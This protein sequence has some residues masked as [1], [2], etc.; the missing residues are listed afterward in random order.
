MKCNS[1]IL[2]PN[3]TFHLANTIQVLHKNP[4]TNVACTQTQVLHKNP[5]T[6]VACTQTQVLHKTPHT[7]VACTQTNVV[8]FLS[9]NGQWFLVYFGGQDLLYVGVTLPGMAAIN[10]Q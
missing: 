5:H 7:N 4:H 2:D 10:Q 3:S 6:N 1:F 9:I 8:C